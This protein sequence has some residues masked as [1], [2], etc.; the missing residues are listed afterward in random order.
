MEPCLNADLGTRSDRLHAREHGLYSIRL[1]S[2]GVSV[3]PCIA[4]TAA[5][6]LTLQSLRF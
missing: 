3:T 2:S 1:F 5:A 6:L 4:Q